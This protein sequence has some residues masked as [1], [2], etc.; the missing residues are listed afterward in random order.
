M[1]LVVLAQSYSWQSR[2]TSPLGVGF[3]DAA[4]K[5]RVGVISM[6]DGG[7]EFLVVVMM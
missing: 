1:T 7:H 3:D 4:M 6:C 5:D 2:W